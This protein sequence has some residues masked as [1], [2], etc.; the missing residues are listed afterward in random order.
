MSARSAAILHEEQP[1]PVAAGVVRNPPGIIV[2]TGSFLLKAAIGL[3]FVLTP[4]TAVLVLG[5]LTRLM[6]REFARRLYRASAG[7]KPKESFASF[8]ARTPEITHLTHWPNWFLSQA[9]PQE[10]KQATGFWAGLARLSEKLFGSLW[11]N[12]KA[13]I[14]LLAALV[15]LTF[16]ATLLALLAWWAGWE[17]SFNKGYEQAWVGPTVSFIGIAFL[18]AAM[19]YLPYAQVRMAVSGHW[20]SFFH[21]RHLR[22]VLRERRFAL[23][24][25]ALL[26][27]AAGAVIAAFKIAPLAVGNAMGNSLLPEEFLIAIVNFF[28]L[29]KAAT[30]LALAVILKARAARIYA[31]AVIATASRQTTVLEDRERRMLNLVGLDRE[32]PQ[33]S[34]GIFGRAA[35][36]TGSRFWSLATQIVIIA[37][38]M[39]FAFLIYAGQF[40]NHDWIDWL[41]HPLV[42]LPWA[43]AL[44]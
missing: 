1:L 7:R 30:V 27:L 19:L 18:I 41:Y 42:Q 4:M 32:I 15:A 2:R 6:E 28:P 25:Y 44:P 34:R 11:L 39:A 26:F 21:L 36:W 12:F 17:N 8:A 35:I 37:A 33:A 5:W 23:V 22:V 24:R 29:A 40:L 43:K 13:G 16:P 20:L 38:W 10:A 31:D 14:R 3:V 9:A